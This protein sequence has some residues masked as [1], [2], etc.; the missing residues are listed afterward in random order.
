MSESLLFYSHREAFYK[1]A[2]SH[3]SAR[4]KR[5]L[6]ETDDQIRSCQSHHSFG[7]ATMI[8]SCELSRSLDIFESLLFLKIQTTSL[9]DWLIHR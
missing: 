8:R 1:V 5:T 9:I 6:I 2:A 4:I 3:A 7:G